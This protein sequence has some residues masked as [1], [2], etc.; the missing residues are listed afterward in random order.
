MMIMNQDKTYSKYDN[1]NYVILAQH[2]EYINWI[3]LNIYM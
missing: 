2:I 3:Q 1:I